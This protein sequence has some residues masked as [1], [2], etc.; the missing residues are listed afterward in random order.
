MDNGLRL[1]KIS[2]WIHLCISTTLR[3]VPGLPERC[4]L[5]PWWYG[6]Q[7][8]V[9]QSWR[10]SRLDWRPSGMTVGGPIWHVRPPN[11]KP[12]DRLVIPLGAEAALLFG[13]SE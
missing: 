2:N 10:L 11:A 1:L 3:A 13:D 8:V 7:D 6:H 12:L 9:P 4:H 5:L